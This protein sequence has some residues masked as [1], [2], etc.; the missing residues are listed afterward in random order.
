M[1]SGVVYLIT[2]SQ[3]KEE[4]IG[5]TGRPLWVRMKE[6]MN[7]LNKCKHSTPL[8]EH[9][10]RSHAGAIFGVAVTVL[11]RE[12]DITVRKTLEALWIAS[13]HPV[14]NRR[15]ERVMVTQEL[16]PFADLC[17]LTPDS[18]RGMVAEEM[19]GRGESQ[20]S[21]LPPS[22]GDVTASRLQS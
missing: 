6:H 18:D 21:N 7:G 1:V 5:E 12:A 3:C 10:L 22:E 8:G 17:G 14:T 20:S 16:A 13:R 11:A 19:T 9:R 4:Y 15:E 2:C